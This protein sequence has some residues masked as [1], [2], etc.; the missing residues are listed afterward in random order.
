MLLTLSHQQAS[1]HQLRAH[2]SALALQHLVA[3]PPRQLLQLFHPLHLASRLAPLMSCPL[4]IVLRLPPPALRLISLALRLLS[5]TLRLLSL[6]LRLLPLAL[7]LLLIAFCLP[8]PLVL[9]LLSLIPNQ[10]LLA[11]RLPPSLSPS[12]RLL[13]IAIPLQTNLHP[14]QKPERSNFLSNR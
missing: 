1:C 10:T 11:L 4:P 6:A 3:N 7:R 9:R 5:L 12:L 2:L 14:T 8:V 13:L